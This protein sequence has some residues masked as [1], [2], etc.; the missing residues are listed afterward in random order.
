MVPQ[1]EMR[2]IRTFQPYASAAQ[3]TSPGAVF[4][5]SAGLLK[6]RWRSRHSAPS[7]VFANRCSSGNSGNFIE[8]VRSL[9]LGHTLGHTCLHSLTYSGPSFVELLKQMWFIHLK[10]GMSLRVLRKMSITGCRIWKAQASERQCKE[11][12]VKITRKKPLKMN[13][14]I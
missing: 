11:N 14:R 2:G 9:I 13:C 12:W 1:W 7:A 5:R 6:H 4:L 8:S 3:V 10:G